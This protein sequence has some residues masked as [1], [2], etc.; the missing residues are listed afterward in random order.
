V[1]SLK[2][3]EVLER[4]V[5]SRKARW[6][7]ELERKAKSWKGRWRAGKEGG[8][9]ERKVERAPIPI[10]K[11]RG[12]LILPPPAKKPGQST[13]SPVTKSKKNLS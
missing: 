13:A 4:K 7:G 2:Y 11:Y 3:N 6:S 10:I 1:E 9:L 8:E 12:D 5:E